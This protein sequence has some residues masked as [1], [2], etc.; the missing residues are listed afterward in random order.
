MPAFEVAVGGKPGKNQ[1]LSRI[2]LEL[3]L[4][5]I[6]WDRMIINSQNKE[7]QN[8]DCGMGVAYMARANPGS[9]W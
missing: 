1:W 5:S 6:T 9:I 3:T 8:D 7:R 4:G 2:A